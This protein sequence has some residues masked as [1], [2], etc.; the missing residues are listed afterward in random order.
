[1]A[2]AKNSAKKFYYLLEELTPLYLLLKQNCLQLTPRPTLPFPR[3][4]ELLVYVNGELL[5]REQASLS[6]LDSAVQGGDACW[7]GIRVY[8]GYLFNC[9]NHLKRLVNSAKILSFEG[10]PTIERL[11]EAIFITCHANHLYDQAHMRLTLTRGRKVTSG[12]DPRL[13][14]YGTSLVILLEYKP[15]VYD[16]S[17]GVTLITS[18]QRRNPPMCLDS[19]IHHNNLLNNILAKIQSNYSHA[20]DAVMLDLDGFVS[21]TN[22]TNLFLCP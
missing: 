9:E 4:K 17:K 11:K 13:N 22:A 18:S 19:K 6:V 12:M 3:N 21:E 10:V 16:N 5:P 20:D 15:P 7:E 2:G 1:L 8:D 14:K